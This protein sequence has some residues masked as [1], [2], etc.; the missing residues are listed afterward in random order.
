[1]NAM[2]KIPTPY[3]IAG[4]LALVA[5]LAGCGPTQFEAKSDLP[6]P[7][8]EK[9]PVTVGVHI[10]REF[11]DKVY[12]E[13]RT[14]QEYSIAL[15]K[16][17]SE[18]FTRMMQAMFTRV[19]MLP[20]AGPVSDTDIRGVLEPVLE[21][22]AFVTPADS[23]TSSY[24]ASLRYRINLYTPQGELT[25][26]WTFTGYGAEPASTMPGSGSDAL[27][28]ATSHAM[29]DAAAKLVVEFRD[30]AIARG[31]VSQLGGAVPT[32]VRAPTPP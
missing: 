19:V 30:Q 1:M 21:D 24:A 11:S 5:L 26:S 20:S 17:Q 31:L 10:P 8:I 9:I 15:G 6:S 2:P 23:G 3:R 12:A 25:D 16:S 4:L 18:G 13:K 32:E 22:F 7:V 27:Q 28:A 14:G 29:R